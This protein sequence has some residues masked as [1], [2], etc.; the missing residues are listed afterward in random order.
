MWRSRQTKE[1]RNAAP[2]SRQAGRQLMVI[3]EQR[4]LEVRLVGC[5]A[6]D[7]PIVECFIS[8]PLED[9]RRLL[10]QDT[11]G[12]VLQAVLV[13]RVVEKPRHAIAEVKHLERAGGA[14]L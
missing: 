4:Q 13:E 12:V 11:E 6:L 2:D 14:P 5:V 7:I 10:E 3:V 1:R 9:E 8:K